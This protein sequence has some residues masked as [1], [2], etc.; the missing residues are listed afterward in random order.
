MLIEPA[1]LLL[2]NSTRANNLNNTGPLT[3]SLFDFLCRISTN[4]FWPLKDQILVGLMQSFKD[5]IEKRVIPSMQVFFTNQTDNMNSKPGQQ[6]PPS[7]A[8]FLDRDLKN[9]IQSTFGNFFQTLNINQA[10]LLQPQQP[11][12]QIVKPVLTKTSGQEDIQSTMSTF[13]QSNQPQ[14]QTTISFG[15]NSS[16]FKQ[17]SSSMHSDESSSGFGSNSENSSPAASPASMSSNIS[18]YNS[19]FSHP[20]QEQQIEQIKSEPVSFMGESDNIKIESAFSSDDDDSNQEIKPTI[21]NSASSNQFLGV[22]QVT[23][24]TTPSPSSMVQLQQQLNQFI[25][26]PFKIFAAPDDLNQNLDNH[27]NLIPSDD[28]RD[29]LVDLNE[30]VK[31]L[32]GTQAKSNSTQSV[33]M[34]KD[35]LN[36]IHR[37]AEM[38]NNFSTSATDLAVSI[39]LILKNDFTNSLLPSSFYNSNSNSLKQSSSNIIALMNDSDVD[40]ISGI[41][42][43]SNSSLFLSQISDSI[44]QRPIFALFKELAF[45]TNQSNEREILNQL[46]HEIYLKQNRIGYYFLYYMHSL[47]LKSQNSMTSN[48]GSSASTA[49]SSSGGSSAANS[50]AELTN[51]LRIYR[52]FMQERYQSY[53]SDSNNKEDKS[54]PTTFNLKV[55]SDSDVSDEELS[56]IKNKNKSN[57]NYEPITSS[58]SS[59][60]SDGDEDDDNEESDDESNSENEEEKFSENDLIL[61][62][63][64]MQDLR[65]CQQDD[66]HLFLFLFPFILSNQDL[67]PNYMINNSELMYLICSCIGDSK[68]LKDL[69]AAIISQDIYLLKEPDPK[70]EVK[71]SSRKQAASKRSTK[72]SAKANKGTASTTSGAQNNKKRK[73]TNSTTK[74]KSKKQSK[75]KKN[76]QSQK[77]ALSSTF[78][79]ENLMDV[80]N[81]SL[82]WETIEQ[83]FFW[84]LLIAH[85]LELENLLPLF[86]KLDSN[87]NSEA[88][89]YFFQLLKTS[90]PTFDLV[91]C[92]VQRRVDDNITRALF[93]HW[94]RSSGEVKMAQL[95]T[96]LLNKSAPNA[97]QQTTLKKIKYNE[98]LSSNKKLTAEQQLEMIANQKKAA[99]GQGSSNNGGSKSTNK[100]DLNDQ[101]K[102]NIPSLDQVLG[103]L[104]RLRLNTNC[105]SFIL[106]ENLLETL[107][108]VYKKYC[109]D[110]LKKKYSDLFALANDSN[111]KSDSEI[112]DVNSDDDNADNKNEEQANNED[113][114]EDEEEENSDSESENSENSNDSFELKRKKKHGASKSKTPTKSKTAA[115]KNKGKQPV[116]KKPKTKSNNSSDSEVYTK[117]GKPKNKANKANQDKGDFDSMS[118]SDSSDYSSSR[119]KKSKQKSKSGS[120]SKLNKS[121]GDQ[122]GSNQPPPRKKLKQQDNSDDGSD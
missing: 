14:L 66:P 116:S 29:K 9:L 72:N 27:L 91:K 102:D 23:N 32:N 19:L 62:Q 7:T 78:K 18:P 89:C 26:R 80:L 117:T 70:K 38:L 99:A 46:L 90:D 100:F 8:P 50:S 44:Q 113:E 75:L 17:K 6:Q 40:L 92:I 21:Q 60:E 105:V 4:Y 97:Q 109:D 35:I 63:C 98:S 54:L 59:N 24:L 13:N 101:E 115:N 114:E 88:I 42:T 121:G 85:D 111:S 51:L 33:N 39:C 107:K 68:Q 119:N 11:A 1:V 83:I 94:T 30:K 86:N 67:I 122:S 2:F 110:E 49:S 65:L 103:H 22:G 28:L 25:T 58:S 95:F 87:R 55:S 34:F 20:R 12:T 73:R 96:K 104:N 61:G 37:D 112:E 118:D 15:S 31:D 106:K 57:S 93:I 52:E 45:T 47:H 5:A 108:K 43:S 48:A 53:R 74:S 76:K 41:F 79:K 77:G 81:T 36:F 64:I 69:V 71:G 10:P 56:S 16:L 3:S 120:N 82:Q 84:E